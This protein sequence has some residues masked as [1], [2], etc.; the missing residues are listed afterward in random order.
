MCHFLRVPEKFDFGQGG[1]KN[2][3]REIRFGCE[4]R[5]PSWGSSEG[6]RVQC[7]NRRANIE[8]LQIMKKKTAT[9]GCKKR[10]IFSTPSIA[11]RV[12]TSTH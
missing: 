10:C 1:G 6:T 11:V 7:D 4:L 12:H 9:D 8:Y 2:I 3:P 5:A